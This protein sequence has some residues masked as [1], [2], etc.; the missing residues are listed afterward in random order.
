MTTARDIMTPGA[1]YIDLTSTVAEAAEKMAEALRLARRSHGVL[2]PTDPPQD[3]WKA[4][5]VDEMIA[6][7]LAAWDASREGGR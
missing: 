1:D 7:A 3:P 2:L 5:R 4:N 6:S